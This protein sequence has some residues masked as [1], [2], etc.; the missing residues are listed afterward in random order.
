MWTNLPIVLAVCLVIL[1]SN[2]G[3]L[4]TENLQ[5]GHDSDKGEIKYQV[6]LQNV[7]QHFCGGT[8]ITA[9]VVL[10]A[11]HCFYDKKKKVYS[12]DPFFVVAGTNDVHD[13]TYRRRVKTMYIH[14]GY[15][16][17][18][19][20]YTYQLYDIAL[21]RVDKVFNVGKNFPI[22][23][24]KLPHKHEDFVGKT[25]NVSGFGWDYAVRTGEQNHTGTSKGKLRQAFVKIFD[26]RYCTTVKTSL[27]LCGRVEQHPGLHS[28]VCPGDSGGPVSFDNKVIGIV[29]LGTWGCDESKEYS[30][31]TRVSEF[32]DFINSVLN[33]KYSSHTIIRKNLYLTF[34]NPE[35][36]R[37]IV[38]KSPEAISVVK[39][40]QRL[41]PELQTRREKKDTWET[42]Y[43]RT[44]DDYNSETNGDVK[45]AKYDKTLEIYNK[46]ISEKKM[47]DD[48]ND[49][50]DNVKENYNRLV[51]EQK[52][53][54]DEF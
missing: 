14:K 1:G 53:L 27:M 54:Y 47:Y 42:L 18:Y 20:D 30:G 33:N 43:N 11:A 8:L 48:V 32:L 3:G 39:E 26:G 15:T 35:E 36:N 19:D 2:V 31:S 49:K 50:M 23:L 40:I 9:D 51:F 25:A 52:I 12:D 24:A 29:S 22:D 10:T 21:V 34:Y 28:G 37:T 6:S 7:R 13:H 5:G 17:A 46:Y 45:Y 41:Y 16:S 4:E 44:L 38:T